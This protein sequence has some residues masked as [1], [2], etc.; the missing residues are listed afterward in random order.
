[1]LGQIGRFLDSAK[2]S[3]GSYDLTHGKTSLCSTWGQDP[4]YLAAYHQ[5][6]Q[7]FSPLVIRGHRVPIGVALSVSD[8]MPYEE[9]QRTVFYQEWTAPQ[10]HVDPLKVNLAKSETE[11]TFV[12]AGRHRLAG[13][14]DEEKRRR[15]D[16]LTP[17]LRRAVRIRDTLW[18]N[19]WNSLPSC[20]GVIPI[21]YPRPQAGEL[22]GVAQQVQQDLPQSHRVDRERAEILCRVNHQPILVLRGRAPD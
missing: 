15:M 21:P 19:S 5:R 20:S 10:G 3:V 2:V 4:Q 16:A 12:V 13:R 11:V 7:K 1:V 17:H 9:F 22:A 6:L 18:E 14:V 8:V